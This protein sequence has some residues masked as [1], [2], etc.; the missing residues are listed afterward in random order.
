MSFDRGGAKSSRALGGCVNPR[1]SG[2]LITA[3]KPFCATRVFARMGPLS[4][5]GSNVSVGVFE[6]KKGFGADGALIGTFWRVR[7]MTFKRFGGLAVG[8]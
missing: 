7:L 8:R 2:E 4:G 3:G 6:T 5:V 1:M